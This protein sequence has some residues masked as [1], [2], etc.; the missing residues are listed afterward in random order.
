MRMRGKEEERRGRKRG[1]GGEKEGNE[2]TESGVCAYLGWWV[3]TDEV[4]PS[5]G[6]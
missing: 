5:K 6:S 4:S 3:S 1:G 2:E